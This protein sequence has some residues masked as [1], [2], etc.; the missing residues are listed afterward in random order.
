MINT[1]NGLVIPLIIL[2]VLVITVGGYYVFY[3]TQITSAPTENSEN[4]TDIV[5]NS[6]ENINNTET[7]LPNQIGN[8]GIVV[9]SIKPND[10]V[11]LP[12]TVE[13]YLDGRGWVANEGE[14]GNVE[15]FDA[16]GKSISNKEIVQTT[17]NWLTFPTYFKAIVGD[18]QMMS[19]ITTNSGFVKITGNGAKDGEQ[20]TS[21][22]I[23]VRFR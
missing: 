1:R 18:R 7:T 21:L 20:V 8:Q 10:L 14:V 17:T 19:Y 11:Q 22:S 23:P 3:K 4:Q 15:I 9:T 12:I 13:G 16:N 6:S 5:N 2:I